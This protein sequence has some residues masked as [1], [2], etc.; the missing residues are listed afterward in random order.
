MCLVQLLPSGQ[1]C[2][3][4]GGWWEPPSAAH[5]QGLPLQWQQLWGVPNKPAAL[6]RASNC[7]PCLA[8]C[9]WGLAV[10]G[11]CLSGHLGAVGRQEGLAEQRTSRKR[12]V[13]PWTPGWGDRAWGVSVLGRPCH[14]DWLGRMLSPGSPTPPVCTPHPCSCLLWRS[15]HL[16]ASLGDG[17]GTCW[18]WQPG[19]PQLVPPLAPTSG[20]LALGCS[21]EGSRLAGSSW[22]LRP[23]LMSRLPAQ[24]A[25]ASVAPTSP[26]PRRRASPMLLVP[27]SLSCSWHGLLQ[28]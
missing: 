26:A 21:T 19:R 1:H 6:P 2:M 3:Q 7:W 18:A 13:Q 10:P 11:G 25:R 24:T 4:A 14:P 20:C 17:V 9:P 27:G 15:P 5:E 8:G 22:R 28:G 23:M 12:G 16:S